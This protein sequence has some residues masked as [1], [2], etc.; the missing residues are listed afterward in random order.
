MPRQF[1]S[2]GKFCRIIT[3]TSGT[4]FNVYGFCYGSTAGCSNT[5]H[6]NHRITACV[7]KC[8][9]R[10]DC[11]TFLS[12]CEPAV[13]NNAGGHYHFPGYPHQFTYKEDRLFLREERGSVTES[14]WNVGQALPEAVRTDRL[15][16][17]LV[18]LD[19]V[20]KNDLKVGRCV[21]FI[22]CDLSMPLCPFTGGGD[23]KSM[24][25]EQNLVVN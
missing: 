8:A 23:M 13:V 5:D 3:W 14:G 16:T 18:D 24:G 10:D 15:H 4:A 1:K 21:A 7:T 12:R 9:S 17:E 2:T 20:K 6:T 11:I 19:L 25:T 22:P